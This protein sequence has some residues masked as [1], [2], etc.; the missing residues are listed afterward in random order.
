MVK[1]E[2]ITALKR[3]CK[4]KTGFFAKKPQNT[5]IR[6]KH[7]S[8]KPLILAVETSGRLG[9]AA[10]ARGG[11][12]L[13]ENAFTGP[14]R[15]SAE[16]FPAIVEL[17]EQFGSRP[18]EIKQVYISI[19][20]GSFTGLRIA[21]TLAKTLHLANAAKIVAVDTLDTIAANANDYIEEKAISLDKV[22][23]ILDAKRGQ[24]FVAAYERNMSCKVWEKIFS[25]SLMTAEQFLDR[26][27]GSDEP[28]WLLGEGLVY[29]R[30]KFKA[31]GIKFLD[32]KYWT[33]QAAKVHLLGWEMAQQGRFAEPIGLQPNYLRGP[34]V[35]G[36]R[37]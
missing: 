30:D 26:F 29:Y 21:V 11:Q 37:R 20:P 28:I 34:D 2:K 9:S 13:A 18:R 19:G 33:P 8:Q 24:F 22:A 31:G 6:N 5:T 12:L 35:K 23:T 15:H 32:E 36:K 25:D 27:A 4:N 14:M 16:V 7:M 3:F 1:Q 17:L 10:I